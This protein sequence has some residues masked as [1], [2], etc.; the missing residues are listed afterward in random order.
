MVDPKKRRYMYIS[1]AVFSA[2]AMGLILFFILLRLQGI[3]NAL[4]TVAEILA[5]FVYGGVIAYLLRPLCNTYE[6]F[7]TDVLPQKAKRF[8]NG[9]A[10]IL[11][12]V[13]GI[14]VVYTLIIMVA[15]QL[16]SSVL[17]LWN[18]LPDKINAFLVWATATFGEDEELLQ[19]FNSSSQKLI[20]ELESW[21]QTTLVPYITNVVS[22]VG[23]SVL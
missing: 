8:A 1:M 4:N 5:P 21:A 17:S 20:A 19:L 12:I 18:S 2:I 23:S 11:S 10:V 16:Y 13:T 6:S 7:F 22:G 14:L 3:G 9:I 15:P